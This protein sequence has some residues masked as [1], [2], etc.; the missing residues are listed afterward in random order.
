MVEGEE[1]WGSS[2]RKMQASTSGG[3]SAQ[4]P[5]LPPKQTETATMVTEGAASQKQ[6]NG[7][8]GGGGVSQEGATTNANTESAATPKR[9]KIKTSVPVALTNA[10]AMI[11]VPN[12][13][14]P[15]QSSHLSASLENASV[16]L[17]ATPKKR[18]C[19]CKQSRC[20]KLYCECFA[21]GIYCN[22]CNCQDCYN[23]KD[24]EQVRQE[25]VEATLE[26]NP[27]AFRPKIQAMS[28]GMSLQDSLKHNKGCNCKRSYCLKRYCECFQANIF[29]SDNCRCVDCKNFEGS[30]SRLQLI[31][32]PSSRLQSPL[33]NFSP[34]AKRQKTSKDKKGGGKHASAASQGAAINGGGA[35]QQGRSVME[36]DPSLAVGVQG[37]G[38]VAVG[39]PGLSPLVSQM[40]LPRSML[41]GIINENVIKHLSTLLFMVAQDKEE[42]HRKQQT[43]AGAAGSD[44]AADD[45][46]GGKVEPGSAT[47]AGEAPKNGAPSAQPETSDTL[48]ENSLQNNHE[49]EEAGGSAGVTSTAHLEKALLCEEESQGLFDLDSPKG[50]NI[51]KQRP[52][53]PPVAA[54]V[55]G[56]S[57]SGVTEINTRETS[58]NGAQ[59][60]NGHAPAVGL[61]LDSIAGDASK[62]AGAGNA[63]G[64]AVGGNPQ[65]VAGL[66]AGS[67][68]RL[69]GGAGQPV[70][71]VYEDQERAILQ[72]LHNCLQVV[73][74]VGRGQVEQIR[75]FL[76][77]IVPL[78]HHMLGGQGANQ[79]AAVTQ[80]APPVQPNEQ[81]GV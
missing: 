68:S 31:Q 72:E 45:A 73:S 77:P 70:S 55:G 9:G 42:A 65:S 28:P 18:R 7:S 60:G 29:C 41:A 78:H 23:N 81:N 33:H 38:Q 52:L 39:H 5:P 20:L 13:S 62:A 50:Y 25:A 63:R 2:G 22:G 67:L 69:A 74:Q 76:S 80:A 58:P 51:N 34:R 3:A 75:S 16:S 79:T 57:K 36:Q 59:K 49:S 46:N 8:G 56:G 4:K 61:S 19:N 71:Q 26:R 48:T 40:L 6:D 10:S 66:A 14:S 27:D 15:R 17:H 54:A 32:S 21:S 24:H 12:L 43:K 35:Q 1:E 11:Q 64:L 30:S 37:A 47:N 53:P 44:R